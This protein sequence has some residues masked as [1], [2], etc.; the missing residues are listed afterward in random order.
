MLV[1]H[2]R[3]GWFREI[4]LTGVAELKEW[5]GM[6][7]RGQEM[8]T[9][10]S[11]QQRGGGTRAAPLGWDQVAGQREDTWFDRGGHKST[12]WILYKKNGQ[13]RQERPSQELPPSP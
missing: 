12:V 9:V 10:G 6:G 11:G 7:G 4:R 1:E 13:E 3:H 2:N 5:P 8:G